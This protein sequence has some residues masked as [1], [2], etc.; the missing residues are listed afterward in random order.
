M[1]LIDKYSRTELEQIANNSQSWRDFIRKLGY[2]SNSGDLKEMIQFKVAELD[3]DTSHFTSFVN[4]IERN[5]ENVFVENSTATQKVLREWYLKGQYTPYIC[6]ICGQEP[7]WQGL[8]L[9][10]ILDHINGINNDDR[11]ENLR[12]VC[13]NCNA[14]LVTTGSRNHKVLAKKY[15]CT[16]GKEIR[17]NSISGKCQ[18]CYN[19]EKLLSTD[20]LPISRE[21]LK[22]LIRTMPFTTIAKQF[23]MS[24]NGIRKWC[25]KFN[26]PRKA[27]EIKRYS[28]DEW[29]KI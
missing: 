4:G 11:L 6:S 28:D 13:P 22:N 10:L 5:V 8:P 1:A 7:E 14:Q 26:L 24:D 2:N 20:N 27:S 25:D 9:T 29:A 15:Y 3:I 17:N 19:R 16:C 21:E 18:E 12:W 23:Q